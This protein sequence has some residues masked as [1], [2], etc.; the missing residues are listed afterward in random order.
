MLHVLFHRFPLA[1]ALSALL[2]ACVPYP[3]E[4]PAYADLCE[5]RQ[6]F[7]VPTAHGV[8]TFYLYTYLYDHALMWRDRPYTQGYFS[9]PHGSPQREF[10]VQVIG[11]NKNRQQPLKAGS[12][13]APIPMLYDS[14]K[15]YLTFEN[16]QRLA[17]RPDLYLGALNNDFPLSGKDYVR[18]S[19]FDI[20]SDEVHRRIPKLTNNS[21]YGSVY[22]AFN[23]PDFNADAKWTINLG[24]LEIDGQSV[25]VAPLQLCHHPKKSWI[26]VEPLMRP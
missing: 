16:G 13:E 21:R 1:L 12:G 3:R 20:N 8:K 14:R 23:T 5:S 11:F 22:V 17:A 15:A 2:V 6:V 10:Y 9:V 18:P 25:T 7:E 26:G 19:P 4:R 24:T